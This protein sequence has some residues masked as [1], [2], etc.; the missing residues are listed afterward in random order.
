[1]PFVYGRIAEGAN[2]TGRKAECEKLNANFK[3]LVNTAIISP[4][5]WGKT[6]LVNRVLNDFRESTDYYVTQIDIFNCRNEEQFYNVFANSV[7]SASARKTDELISLA[8]KYLG[9]LAPK[10]TLT[11]GGQQMELSLGVDF[12]D[13]IYSFDEILDL[14]QK[15]ASER[16]EKFIV[17][18]DE[19]QN[20]NTYDDSLAFQRKLRSHWQLHNDV[21]YCLYGSKRHMLIDIFGNYEMPFYKFGDIMFLDKIP[22]EQ[23]IPFII[24]RFKDSGKSI[25]ANSAKLIADKVDCHPYYVQQLSQQAWLRTSDE[26]SEAI[27]DETFISMIGQMNLVFSNLIDSLRPKQLSFLRAIAEGV[28]NFTSKDTLRKYDLGTS[29]NVK[30]LRKAVI[31]RDIIDILPN[32]KIEIQ[33]PLFKWWFLNDY[34]K[35][36]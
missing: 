16:G 2:F 17:C 23:W 11:D 22:V 27:I 8:K 28:R 34:I 25:S 31:D 18:I 24:N 36:L 32:D 14:P 7:I 13:T 26:C 4:R 29:A 30:N 21:G 35:G 12:R 3:G 10:I 19:F 15:I 6:S 1:M 9:S 5:R 20:V 33:D